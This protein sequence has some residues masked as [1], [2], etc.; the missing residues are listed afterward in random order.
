MPWWQLSGA[1]VAR[2]VTAPKLTGNP[3]LPDGRAIAYRRAGWECWPT[4]TD[5]GGNLRRY[6]T[7]DDD[8]TDVPTTR[9]DP[10]RHPSTDHDTSAQAGS[11]DASGQ[12]G[13]GVRESGGATPGARRS[14]G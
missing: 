11:A 3:R 7:C 6:R 12:R 13:S 1:S 4:A 14:A 10:R 2:G 8:R 9:D 5:T